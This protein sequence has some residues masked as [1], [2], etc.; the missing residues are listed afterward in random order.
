MT[1]HEFETW[2]LTYVVKVYHQTIHNGINKTPTQQWQIGLFGDDFNEGIGI[3]AL[4]SNPK[5]I[6][7]DFMPSVERTI[8]RNGVN[9][10]GLNYYDPSLNNFINQTDSST[11][12]KKQFTFRQ[13]P[14]DI[15]IIWF[16]DP[17]LKTYFD[18]PLANQALPAMSLWEYKQLYKQVKQ[19]SGTVNESLIYQAWEDMQALVET[20]EQTTKT[21]RRQEQRRKSHTKSQEIHQPLKD[22]ISA[23]QA[24]A[25]PESVQPIVE[26]DDGLDFFEDIR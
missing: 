19:Q 3:P 18:I 1:L 11:K 16:Y 15:S 24:I 26:D 14:R 6:L 7:L 25:K 5:T 17:I 22:D 13:D 23:M 20:S 2:F 4:P 21:L 8:Q 9:I 12:K 10:G